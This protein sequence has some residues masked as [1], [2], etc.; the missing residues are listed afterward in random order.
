MLCL[1]RTEGARELSEVSFMRALIPFVRAPPSCPNHLS[2]A[3][4]FN[5]ITLR[6]RSLTWEFGRHPDTPSIK[7]G[8]NWNVSKRSR[9]AVSKDTEEM[10]YSSLSLRPPLPLTDQCLDVS[11]TFRGIDHMIILVIF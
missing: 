2:E 3:P 9:P 8:P 4:P 5:T 7:D 1:H 10:G 11:K 6:V